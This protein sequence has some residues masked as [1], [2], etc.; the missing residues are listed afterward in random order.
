MI[1]VSLFDVKAKTYSPPHPT[2]NKDTAIRELAML[3]NAGDK[4]LIA[5]N[6]EDYALYSVGEWFDR[7]PVDG[8]V[9]S[10]TAKL[11]ANQ[12]F[13]HLCNAADLVKEK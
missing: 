2:Q 3:V 13:E 11:V 12:T 8:K 10:Y 4:S 5:T 9:D 6:P 1:L 7:V